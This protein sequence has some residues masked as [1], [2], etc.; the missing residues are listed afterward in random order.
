MTTVGTDKTSDHRSAPPLGD[1]PALIL[2]GGGMKVAFQAGVL[3]VWLDE[4][5]IPFMLADGT[6]GGTFNLAMYCQGM[7]GRQIAD[8]WRG[9]RPRTGIS[10]NWRTLPRGPFASSIFTFDRYRRRVFPSWGLDWSR[11]AKTGK[12]A[13][14]NVYDFTENELVACPAVD[15]D[16]DLLVACNSI[17]SWFPPVHKDGRSYLDAV[18]VTDANLE[19][20][21]A[22]GA[23]DIFVI[24]TVS[25]RGDWQS[26]FVA[27]YFQTIEEAA[28][29]HFRR[30]CDRIHRSNRAIA[31]GRHAEFERH[32]TLRV[33]RFPVPLHYIV[34]L[35]Q[36]RLAAAVELG[37]REARRWCA[38][39]DIALKQL[40]WPLPHPGYKMDFSEQ[41]KGF[42]SF[43]E[44][45]PLVG[46]ERGKTDGTSLI[47][48]LDVKIPGLRRFAIDPDHTAIVHGFVRADQL[49]GQLGIEKGRLNLFRSDGDPGS[50]I[51]RYVLW[52]RDGVGHKVTFVGEKR[53]KNDPGWDIWSD[54]TTLFCRISRG[55]SDGEAISAD[56]LLGSGI[57]RISLP[58]VVRQLTTLKTDARGPGGRAEVIL[59][60]GQFFLGR[61]FDV[62]G[63]AVLSSS[64]F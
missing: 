36:D 5:E 25:E 61:L 24:W 18:Y 59:R 53:L 6:S 54:T 29:G 37:V 64:P 30:V 8:N 39:Q 50:A 4:A 3:Q 35:S 62:Y 27:S 26:G 40:A 21:I 57:L 12:E 23:D 47:L 9:F 14:F 13:S 48:D 60:F 10:L 16:E 22:R 7:T 63:Q 56:D 19:D 32:I 58:A 1:R 44:S 41:M 34:N 43:G 33:L 2:A 42:F 51:M 20:A 49:G 38:D 55:H 45:D 46:A 15:M 11:I 52:F 17:P 28:N 31:E